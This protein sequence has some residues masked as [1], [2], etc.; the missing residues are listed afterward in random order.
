MGVTRMALGR[1][2]LALAGSV[3]LAVLAKNAY[4]Y[5]GA[6]PRANIS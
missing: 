5:L 4:P 1:T 2:L 6:K 3:D